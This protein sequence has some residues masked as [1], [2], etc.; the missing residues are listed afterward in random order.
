M[1]L[2]KGTLY[3]SAKLYTERTF[4]KEAARDALQ[5]LDAADRDVLN[6]VVAVGWYPLDAMLRY[7]L[8][9]DRRYGKGDRKIVRE[10]GRFG[11]EWQLNTFHKLVLRFKDPHWMIE[12][13]ATMWKHYHD[14]G[15]WEVGAKVA[16]HVE[17]KLK[18]FVVPDDTQCVRLSGWF[19][20]AIELT[21]GKNVVVQEAQCI[22]RKDPHCHFL[23]SWK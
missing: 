11:A 17:G 2:A 14:T 22:A 10:I 7:H 19:A 9:V 16:N 6:S 12:R 15:E 1:P 3:L 21:G 23:A 13:A 8:A 20:R 4:G 18:G 5:D